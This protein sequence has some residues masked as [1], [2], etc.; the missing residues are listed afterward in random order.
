MTR[1]D[2]MHNANVHEL[3]AIL[4]AMQGPCE[5]CR[6][7]DIKKESPGILCTYA[8]LTEDVD[9]SDDKEE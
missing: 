3:A 1:Y 9:S 4:C 7:R 8:W 5:E 2:Q 6:F